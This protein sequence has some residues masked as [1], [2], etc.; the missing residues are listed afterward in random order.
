MR[1]V[2]ATV[3]ALLL[4]TVPAGAALRTPQVPVRGSALQSFLIA[5]GQAIDVATE[6]LALERQSFAWSQVISLQALGGGEPA[7]ATFGL[8]NAGL[9]V[10]PLYQLWPGAAAPGWY[11][12][13]SFRAAPAR[14]VVNLFDVNSILQG[15]TT[16]LAGPPDP[17]DQ[18]F[19]C[20]GPTDTAY[21]QDS[22]NAAG[23]PRMLAFA[24]TGAQR[25]RTWLAW[26]SSPGPSADFADVIY[27][28]GD[29]LT[30]VAALHTTWG[31]L[32]QRFR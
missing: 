25:G 20:S 8:Y 29:S 13:A 12:V 27:L 2:F 24:A 1:A 18:G 31:V 30:P 15:T 10:P 4:F 17:A 5:Q 6:Q 16:Y 26:E 22:R 7:L 28:L 14:L 9:A 3:F 11:L 23:Q 21:S 32:K 19:Y